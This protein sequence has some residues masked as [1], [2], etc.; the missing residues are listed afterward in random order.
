MMPE[1]GPGWNQ[2]NTL[3]YLMLK[4]F[5]GQDAVLWGKSAVLVSYNSNI[6]S[7]MRYGME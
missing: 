5:D 3:L 4:T 1:D 6:S 7:L 2:S